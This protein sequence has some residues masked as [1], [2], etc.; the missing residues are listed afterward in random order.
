M[1]VADVAQLTNLS[2][3]V[4]SLDEESLWALICLLFPEAVEETREDIFDALL[5]A[6]RRDGT[7]ISADDAFVQEDGRRGISR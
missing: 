2:Q 7:K 4:F 6:S 5:S 3:Q 1:P